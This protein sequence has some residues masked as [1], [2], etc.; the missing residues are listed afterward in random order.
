MGHLHAGLLLQ[1]FHHQMTGRADGPGAVAVLVRVRLDQVDQLQQ[2][3]RR[4]VAVDEQIHASGGRL[5]DRRE[6][7]RRIVGQRPDDRRR[8]HCCRRVAVQQGVAVGRRLLH[9]AHG[10]GAARP[11]PVFDDDRLL[12]RYR[13]PPRERAGEHVGSRPGRRRGDYR[14]RPSG[15]RLVGARHGEVQE[16]GSA[17]RQQREGV[18]A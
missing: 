18:S 15:P 2:V 4:D 3:L 14:D 7:L 1:P 6:V 11:G 12:E 9:R 5:R 16:C 8:D 17:K 10:D 13:Q